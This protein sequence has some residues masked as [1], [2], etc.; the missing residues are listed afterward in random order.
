[1]K[2][3]IVSPAFDLAFILGPGIAI[4]L[5]VLL[6]PESIALMR[7]IPLWIWVIAVLGIDVAHVY[8]T[9]FRTYLDADEFAARRTLYLMAPIA[10]FVGGIV[11]HSID[12]QI[13]WRALAYLAV[14]HFIRQQ[15]GFMAIYG[16]A[17]E[18]PRWGV[19]LDQCAIYLATLYPLFYWHLHLPRDF[20]WFIPGDFLPLPIAW[21]SELALVLYGAVLALYVVKESYLSIRMKQVN[22]A[23]HLLLGG[24]AL[25]WYVGI[26]LLNGDLAFT[27]TNVI[28]HGVPYMALVWAYQ[29][30]KVAPADRG[31]SWITARS[32]GMFVGIVV[33]LA[34][35]EEFFWDTFVWRE[36]AGLFFG[37]FALPRISSP[38]LL[39]LVVPLLAVPQATHYVLDAFIWRVS[40]PDETF[41]HMLSEAA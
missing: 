6:L 34:F 38:E 29:R 13:F 11:L 16:R 21:P 27:L 31:R 24:T 37:W 8:S 9:L 14:F 28:T 22:F 4:S 40:K 10:C 20:S 30:K 17:S 12:S 23:K 7:D 19:R 39:T 18:Q 33:G 15:Y 3:W 5:L 35:V 2:R 41:K 1:M 25:S 36:R 26:V 32:I